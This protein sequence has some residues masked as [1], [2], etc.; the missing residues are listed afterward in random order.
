MTCHHA[1]G[2]IQILLKKHV[3]LKVVNIEN[4]DKWKNISPHCVADSSENTILQAINGKQGFFDAVV[5]LS[6]KG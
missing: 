1:I 2:W 3:N 6:E 5:Y 4:N